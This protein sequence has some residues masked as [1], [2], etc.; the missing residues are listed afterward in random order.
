MTVSQRRV[1]TISSLTCEL[2]VSYPPKSSLSCSSVF[3]CLFLNHAAPLSHS[4][5]SFPSS[6][7]LHLSPRHAHCFP[8]SFMH[9]S[10]FPLIPSFSPPLHTCKTV[11][12]H[13]ITAHP[14]FP[15]SLYTSLLAALTLKHTHAQQHSPALEP[16]SMATQS[17][18]ILQ[19]GFPPNED[20]PLLSV[21]CVCMCV[22]MRFL[23]DTMRFFIDFALLTAIFTSCRVTGGE[24]FEDIVAR[25]YYS[26]A[27]A[28]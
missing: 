7:V 18:W 11:H 6:F 2:F 12:P 1:S 4:L 19:P 14:F 24:L 28:R 8:P 23:F 22:C 16:V 9:R 27:D 25:E 10:F 20:I 17:E 13:Y 3:T 26:E 5:L 15:L 21:L